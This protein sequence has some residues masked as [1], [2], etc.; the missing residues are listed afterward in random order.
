MDTVKRLLTRWVRKATAWAWQPLL[1]AQGAKM[2]RDRKDFNVQLEALSGANSDLQER[3]MRTTRTLAGTSALLEQHKNAQRALGAWYSKVRDDLHLDGTM[4]ATCAK[5]L[6]DRLRYGP[7]QQG[8]V[9]PFARWQVP[10]WGMVP[11]WLQ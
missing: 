4:K 9:T 11:A 7:T 6:I 8:N 2:L 3:L 10:T 5:V 1:E